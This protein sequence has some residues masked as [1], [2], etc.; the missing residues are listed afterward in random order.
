[1]KPLPSITVDGLYEKLQ[2]GE[3]I[4]VLDVRF[5]AELEYGKIKYAMVIPFPELPEKLH[6]LDK[7]SEL[8]VYCRTD[9]RSQRAVQYLLSQGFVKVRYLVGGIL[10]WKK[11]DEGVQEY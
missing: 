4:T 2:A 3:E 10:A 7:E 11:Y 1:M 9:N 5:T 8:V 6:I